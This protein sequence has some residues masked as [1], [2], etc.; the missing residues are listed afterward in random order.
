MIKPRIIIADEDISYII[1]MQQKFIEEFFEK[2]D[3]EIITDK[4][5]YNEFF[6]SP[7]KADILIV[8]EELYDTSLQRHNIANIFLMTEQY[9]DDQ[10]CDL[11]VNRIFKYTSIKEIFNEIMGKSAKTLKMSDGSPKETQIILVYSACGGAGK[12]TVALG[13]SDYLAKNYKRILYINAGRLQS[14]YGMFDNKTPITAGDVYVKLSNPS[15][16]IYND[17]KHVIRQERFNYLPPFKASLMSLGLN[18]SVYE[19]IVVGA[20]KSTDYD[21]II[22]DADSSFDED[23]VKLMNLADKV[24][25]I[26]KQNEASVFGT[27]IL[28]SNINDSNSDKYAYICND[29]NKEYNNAII[30][31]DIPVKFTV[32]DYVEHIKYYDQIKLTD[33][34]NNS[35]IQRIAFLIV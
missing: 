6:S 11:S 26:T 21:Y 33:L 32:S 22:I 18:Y 23:L 30:S 14:F 28:M 2:A 12:T 7:Q 29:F 4:K 20:K 9:A 34:S 19:K 25:I 13:V 24:L 10:T 5:Y 17:V 8:S 15:D 1:P 16:D 31:Q 27:N 35:G 3:I